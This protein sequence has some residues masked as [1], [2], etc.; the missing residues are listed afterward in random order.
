[1]LKLADFAK[2]TYDITEF[3]AVS[4]DKLQ[5]KAIQTAIDTCYQ[6]GG[7]WVVV[8]E[9]RFMTGDIRLRSDVVLYLKSGA[10][11]KGSPDPEDYMN[12]LSDQVE[13]LPPYQGDCKKRSVNP[14]SRWNSGL[15][16]AVAAERIAV[17]GEPGSYIDGGNVYD[18]QGEEN[19]RGPHAINMYGCRDI[20]LEGYT[21]LDSANWAHNIYVSQNITARN[22]KVLGGHDGFDVRS[23]DNI[24]IENCNF[25][26][27]DDCIAGFD[28]YNVHIHDCI[29]D[30]ACSALRFGGTKVLVENCRTVAPAS[31]G[32]RWG[33]STEDKQRNVLPGPECRHNMHTPFLYYC[34]FRADIR[35]TPGDILIR[36]CEFQNPDAL[37]Q[38]QFDG[39]H[40]WC[41]NRSLSQ[42]KFENCRAVGLAEPIGIHGDPEEPIDFELENCTLS[43]RAG[44]EGMALA[45]AAHFKR[46]TLKKVLVDG[47]EN[48]V[49]RKYT[50]GEIVLED[51]A[52]VGIV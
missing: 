42:I 32:H 1:M 19:Y 5:T 41:C 6:R 36:N 7:G 20:L 23:C 35:H 43:A 34:D 18:A 40:I 51:T 28:N 50:D 30:C 44:F 11:L 4:S 31:F 39:K 52:G 29:L 26:T 45:E 24:V 48:P 2:T 47:Y 3:G 21:V 22:L 16:K 25:C 38:L 46:I 27:G 49:I 10:I 8:P 37:F 33:M 13:P 9:G 14:Y 17:I 15:I 12:Y